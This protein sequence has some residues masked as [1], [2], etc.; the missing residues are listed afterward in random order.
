MDISGTDFIKWGMGITVGVL[1]ALGVTKYKV[2][3]I[4]ADI[5]ELKNSK[6]DKEP[7]R[8]ELTELKNKMDCID[9]KMSVVRESQARTE[10]AIDFI[11]KELFIRKGN[12]IV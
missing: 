10:T 5:G 6:M 4:K 3:T 8:A 2:D 7:C 11:T 1:S 12:G 9:K